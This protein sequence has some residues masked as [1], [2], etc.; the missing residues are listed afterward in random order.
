MLPSFLVSF[1]RERLLAFFDGFLVRVEN[2]FFQDE[3][4]DVHLHDAD[5][6]QQEAE[7]EDKVDHAEVP[8]ERRGRIGEF[9]EVENGDVAFPRH[10]ERE[11]EPDHVP[12]EQEQV[13]HP[14]GRLGKLQ[15]HAV[16]G[17][18]AGRV[19]G[20]E[21]DEPDKGETG[22]F[23]RPRKG[24]VD[25]PQHDLKKDDDDEKDQ[26][27]LAQI[28]FEMVQQGQDYFFHVSYSSSRRP[29]KPRGAFPERITASVKA[30]RPA[31]DGADTGVMRVRRALTRGRFACPTPGPPPQ[32]RR[33]PCDELLPGGLAAGL[34]VVVDGFLAADEIGHF[35]PYLVESGLLPLVFVFQLGNDEAAG[36]EFLLGGFGLFHLELQNG[37]LSVLAG[38]NHELLHFGGHLAVH[39]FADDQRLELVGVVD[40]GEVFLVGFVELHGLEAD[41]AV[42]LAVYDALLER[43]EGFGPGDGGRAAAE[44]LVRGDEHGALRH[45]ELQ[46]LDV[47][48]LG[49][50]ALGVGDVA[51]V[52]VGPGQDAESGLGGVGVQQL[53]GGAVGAGHDFVKVGEEVG[54][55]QQAQ[56]LFE[57]NEVGDA[58]HGQRQGALLHVAEAF[59]F[60][61]QSAAVEALH[62]HFAAGFF[63]HVLLEGITDDAH[64]GVFGVPHRDFQRRFRGGGCGSGPHEQG[65][66]Q[67]GQ[68]LLAGHESSP[69]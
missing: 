55:G 12:D 68:N 6:H 48:H 46:A 38:V 32:T 24:H 13:A 8:V 43:G 17:A 56:T 61:A 20:A 53:G 15:G 30:R 34:Q 49:D 47:G 23:F 35:G 64:F 57:R 16:Q 14:F 54:Q 58:A 2:F 37:V 9:H 5:G 45:A 28:T 26:Q 42:A 22:D 27:E 50:R 31:V 40:F 18:Q 69:L 44:G 1:S 52:G 29:V 62:F 3:L 60:V 39:A 36:D 66:Q 59:A 67:Q 65:R 21:Q 63:F 19:A 25:L 7:G 11:A 10:D 4:D 41:I 33:C 51:E